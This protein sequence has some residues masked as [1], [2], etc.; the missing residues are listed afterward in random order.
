MALTTFDLDEYVL[1]ALR[2]GAVGFLLESTSPEDLLDL[3][4]VA[5]A[6]HTVPSSALV[7]RRHVCVCRRLRVRQVAGG[8]GG[9]KR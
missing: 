2:A 9:D 4:R 6:G 3:V 7:K 5:A 1:R 8:Q